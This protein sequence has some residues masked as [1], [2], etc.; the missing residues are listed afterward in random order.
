MF[1]TTTGGNL[2]EIFLSWRQRQQEREKAKEDSDKI[3][4]EVEN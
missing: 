1:L 3:K 4:N 2:R